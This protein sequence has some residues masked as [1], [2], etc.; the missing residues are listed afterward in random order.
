[1]DQKKSDNEEPIGTNSCAT[2]HVPLAPQEEHSGIGLSRFSSSS[3]CDSFFTADENASHMSPDDSQSIRKTRS[4]ARSSSILASSSSK[5]TGPSFPVSSTPFRG[6]VESNVV[7][8]GT[9]HLDHVLSFHQKVS[10]PTFSHDIFSSFALEAETPGS[11]HDSMHSYFGNWRFYSSGIG[12]SSGGEIPPNSV[13]AESMGD[14]D[15]SEEGHQVILLPRPYSL[16]PVAKSE[17]SLPLGYAKPSASKENAMPYA[18]SRKRSKSLSA[19]PIA[20]AISRPGRK[21]SRLSA[22]SRKD[23][24]RAFCMN[25]SSEAMFFACRSPEITEADSTVSSVSTFELVSNL[26]KSAQNGKRALA[27]SKL[28]SKPFGRLHNVVTRLLT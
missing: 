2:Q 3:V 22:A 20:P 16:S 18:L 8:G 27:R 9:P 26:N 5:D 17:P 25:S 13:Y 23:Q 21:N 14:N 15:S 6:R 24:V 4:G 12:D 19:L 11:S 28:I 1:M 7:P 10:P